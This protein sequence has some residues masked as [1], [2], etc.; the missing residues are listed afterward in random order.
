MDIK[1]MH[2]EALHMVQRTTRDGRA[3]IFK[4]MEIFL[5][6]KTAYDTLTHVEQL[7]IIRAWQEKHGRRTPPLPEE[8]SLY[9]LC[10]LRNNPIFWKRGG[11]FWWWAAHALMKD[12]NFRIDEEG[13]VLYT[14]PKKN[15][16]F[17]S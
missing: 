15:R 1:E 3:R 11:R 9:P 8:E 14:L 5:V 2:S 4:D 7:E 6:F 17:T 13:R 10:W 16:T 12:E